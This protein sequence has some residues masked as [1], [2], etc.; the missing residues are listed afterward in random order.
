V[1]GIESCIYFI[2]N[3]INGNFYIGS[4]VNFAQRRSTHFTRL[5]QNKH[6]NPPLQRAVNLYGI[7][8]FEINIYQICNKIERLDLE[9]HYIT[10]M[11][12]HYNIAKSATAPMQG[13]RHTQ[14][15][16]Q[17]MASWKRP[18]GLDHHLTGKT[19]NIE[20]RRKLSESRTGGKRTK[21]TKLKMSETAKRI[22]SISRI[23]REKAKRR[24]VDQNGTIYPSLSEAARI[25]KHSI[26]AICDNLKGRSIKTKRKYSFKYT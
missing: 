1:K 5:K 13:R 9:T 16:K 19:L 20:H 6:H 10:T 4:T 11:N 2:T 17:M 26:Q 18:K 22:N 12:P 7:E 21:T 8:N 23:D 14:H 24:I 3:N 15:S 25:T